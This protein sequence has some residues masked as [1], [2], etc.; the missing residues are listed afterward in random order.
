MFVNRIL[1]IGSGIGLPARLLYNFSVA[2]GN[3]ATFLKTNVE[4]RWET[5]GKDA[6]Q[7]V[8]VLVDDHTGG[9]RIFSGNAGTYPVVCFGNGRGG[10][11]ILG[12]RPLAPSELADSPGLAARI[13][14]RL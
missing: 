8:C 3:L 11:D 2:E 14:P 5:H 6:I 7:V 1:G 4:L 13:R 9:V 10:E 12:N